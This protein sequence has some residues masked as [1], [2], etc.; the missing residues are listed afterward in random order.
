M[1]E[2]IKRDVVKLQELTTS[3]T[4]E[5]AYESVGKYGHYVGVMLTGNRIL[6]LNEKTTAYKA[7]TSKPLS[8]IIGKGMVAEKRTSKDGNEYTVA[9][10][11]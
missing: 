1:E 4:I 9:K 6:F 10:I 7:L 5:Y 8:E 2:N 11:V 3:A